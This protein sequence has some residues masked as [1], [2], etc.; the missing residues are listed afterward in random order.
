MAGATVDWTRLDSMV[1][2]MVLRR[3]PRP[4]Q[5]LD[6]EDLVQAGLARVWARRDVYDPEKASFTSWALCEAHFGIQDEFRKHAHGGRGYKGLQP[7]SL[8]HMTAEDGESGAIQDFLEA[9]D[10]V[11]AEVMASAIYDAANEAVTGKTTRLSTQEQFVVGLMLWNPD[12]TQRNV[13][14]MMGLG[15]ARISQLKKS[16]YKKLYQRLRAKGV[17]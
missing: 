11:E 9:P 12:M 8:N 15:E 17:L 3:W 7:T 1:R 6:A 5:P 4:F 2:A 13:A 10:N 14:D 16:G